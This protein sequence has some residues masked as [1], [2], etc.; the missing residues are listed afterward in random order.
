MAVNILKLNCLADIRPIAVGETIRRPTGKHQTT[1]NHFNLGVAC[2]AGS[3]RVIHSLRNMIDCHWK[4]DSFAVIKIDTK[5]TFNLVSR[6][7]LF[8]ECVS[9]FPELALWAA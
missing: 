5:N 7:V 9:V 4:D 2:S 8:S 6:Q 3:E 1:S